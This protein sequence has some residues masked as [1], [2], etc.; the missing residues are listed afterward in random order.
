MRST[1]S[2][3]SGTAWICDGCDKLSAYTL[4]RD[5]PRAW[6]YAGSPGGLYCPETVCQQWAKAVEL[7]EA[8]RALAEIAPKLDYLPREGAEWV[9][10]SARVRELAKQILAVGPVQPYGEHLQEPDEDEEADA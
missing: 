1:T 2:Q 6:T 10:T 4:G 7:Q 5:P 3:H 8:A 9:R